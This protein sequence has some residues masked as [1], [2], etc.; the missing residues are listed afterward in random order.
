[1][2]FWHQ[3][4]KKM[5]MVEKFMILA[6]C[7]WCF[8]FIIYRERLMPN[9]A[10]LGKDE[11][12]IQAP[13]CLF[14]NFGLGEGGRGGQRTETLTR[15]ES[16]SPTQPSSW[17]SHHP[18]PTFSH[19]PNQIP[20]SPEPATVFSPEM[21]SAWTPS[22]HILACVLCSS[23]YFPSFLENLSWIISLSLITPLHSPP[24]HKKQK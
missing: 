17:V 19:W 3:W 15:E 13:S 10:E 7:S 21:S 4:L 11:T 12:F 2:V 14:T 1:M 22:P 16:P 18:A 8:F 9:L 6:K 5:K 20:A 24:H 23:T